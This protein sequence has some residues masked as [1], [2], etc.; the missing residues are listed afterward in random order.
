MAGYERMV[1]LDRSSTKFDSDLLE[2]SMSYGRNLI[3]QSALAAGYMLALSNP[4]FAVAQGPAD[5][6]G[7]KKFWRESCNSAQLRGNNPACMGEA[8]PPPV[9]P[10]PSTDN[11]GTTKRHTPAH[12]GGL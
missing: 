9:E 1:T 12:G 7:S 8:P 11:T 6:G 4:A 2:A 10:A 3:W 5:S